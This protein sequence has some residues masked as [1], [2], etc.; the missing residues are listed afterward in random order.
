MIREI[1]FAGSLSV[2]SKQS[3]HTGTFVADLIQ[4]NLPGGTF[5][6]AHG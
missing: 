1:P 2:I 5:F 6:I 4:K 3:S